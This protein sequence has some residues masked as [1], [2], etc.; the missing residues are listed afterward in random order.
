MLDRLRWVTLILAIILS[1]LSLAVS[2]LRVRIQEE[3]FLSMMSQPGYPHD[4]YSLVSRGRYGERIQSADT[5]LRVLLTA[6]IASHLVI[7][8]RKFDRDQKCLALSED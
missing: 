6:T 5:L 7:L 3:P 8:N 1:C 2:D 4:S